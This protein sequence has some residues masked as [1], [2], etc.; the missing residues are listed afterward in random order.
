MQTQMAYHAVRRQKLTSEPYLLKHGRRLPFLHQLWS[1]SVS[2]PPASAS[3]ASDAIPE[4]LLQAHGPSSKEWRKAPLAEPTLRF[5]INYFESGTRLPD[6]CS[7]DR[8]IDR[9]YLKDW[10]KFF[11][12]SRVLH[13][14][15]KLNGQ[16]F[17]QLV[18][19]PDYRDIVFHALHDDLG[20]QG[21]DRTTS[22]MKQRFFWP[23]MDAFI[24]HKIR[25]CDRC[26]LRNSRGGISAELVNTISSS[27]IHAQCRLWTFQARDS[28]Y[29][30]SFA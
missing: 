15:V 1:R 30:L 23:G 3:S 19:P 27:P 6:R 9:R 2:D 28:R 13:R 26:I 10:I 21:R 4:Q 7:I 22:L 25:T 16:E 12:S 24:K 18:L 14:K 5:I 8:Q 17:L 20:H 29:R 11:I